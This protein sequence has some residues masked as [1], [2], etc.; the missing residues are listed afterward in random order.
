[1]VEYYTGQNQRFW[2]KR[3]PKWGGGGSLGG[4]LSTYIFPILLLF[5]TRTPPPQTKRR[6]FRISSI[7]PDATEGELR[8]YLKDLLEDGTPDDFIISLVPYSYGKEQMATVSFTYK[9]P[10]QFSECKT[11]ERLYLRSEGMKSRIIVDCNF[12]GV[13]PLYSAKEPTAE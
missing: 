10:E 13:T 11:D 8:A 7:P 1:V 2:C 4:C 9:E 5:N 6:T 12:Q 3:R